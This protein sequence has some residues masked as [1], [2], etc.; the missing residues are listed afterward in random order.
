[1]ILTTFDIIVYLA[2]FVGFFASSFYILTFIASFKKNPPQF[3]DKE[4]PF[5]T[6]II[7]AWNEEKSVENTLNSIL[8]SDYPNFEIV[9]VDDGSSDKTYKI[10]K[11][12]EKLKNV[13][14]FTK[15]NGGKASAVNL[16]ISKARGEII[17]TMDADTRVD[18][19]SMKK[20]VRYFKD[21]QVM[22]VTPAMLID[23]KK[24]IKQTVLQKVQQ[25]EYYLGVFLRKVFAQLN[26][27]Y[28]APGAFSAYRKSFFEKHGGYDEGNIVEDLEMAMRIQSK[29]YRTENS[30][31]SAI[32]TLGPRTFRALTKQRVRWYWGLI[33]NFWE[34]RY[35]VNKKYADLGLLVMPIGWITISFSIFLIIRM[36]IKTFTITIKEVIFLNSIGFDFG[37][38]FGFTWYGIEKFLYELFSNPITIFMIL[39]IILVFTYL[40]YS[41]STT[42]KIKN[43]K[44]TVFW[45]FLLFGPLFVYWW[46]LS[47]L[48]AIYKKKIEWR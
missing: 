47:I 6:V 17:F 31:T 43:I 44:S 1:M 2:I 32:Y 19:T 14:V 28:I 7:P 10:A 12:F 45:F 23:R 24:G 30:P 33:K 8:S 46:L 27:I 36:F 29:G 3:K 34:Y 35:M 9:F 15:K 48:K 22:S 5:V 13:R 42:E 21:P 25:I 37:G 39:S 11:K 20:M 41:S 26:A 4:L 16:G 40:K 18:S 38:L